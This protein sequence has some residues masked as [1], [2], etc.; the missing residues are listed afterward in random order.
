MTRFFSFGRTCIRRRRSFVRGRPGQG[1]DMAL[2]QSEITMSLEISNESGPENPA[3]SPARWLETPSAIP[4]RPWAGYVARALLTF[5]F[6]ASGLAKLLD[7]DAGLAEM[8][9]FGLE[10]A[11]PF[12]V[13]T[14]AVQLGGSLMVIL[15]RWTWVGAGA[16]AVFT[17]LTIPIAHDFWAMEEPLKTLEFHVAMEHITVV[18]GLLVA[19]YASTLRKGTAA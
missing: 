10:P 5:M 11:M 9:H 3:T 2:D 19:I 4:R 13:A 15:N 1:H 14:V 8:R 18:G 12:Y 7:M 17:L 16:L 6:W